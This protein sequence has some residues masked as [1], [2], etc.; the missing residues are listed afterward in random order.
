MFPPE[1]Q[2]PR[3]SVLARVALAAAAIVVGVV[4]GVAAPAFAPP[5]SAAGASVTV[6]NAK[7]TAVADPDYAT[8]ITV[9]GR[10]FQSIQGG[11]G[12]IYVLFGW[13]S[14]GSWKPSAGGVIGA[15]YRYVP[16]TES[17]DNAGFE[18]FIAF[19]GSETESA[20][21]GVIAA[22]GSWSTTMNIPGATFE[23]LDRT[24]KS[25]EVDCLKVTCGVIT[26]GAHGVKNGNNETFT[27]VTFAAP[28]PAAAD[29]PATASAG[30]AGVARVGYTT[31]SAVAGN[32]LS[33]TGKGFTPGEQVVATLD[34]GVAAVGPLTAGA[35][36]DVAG[37]MQLPMDIR[38]GTHLLTLRGAAT[39]TVAESE[40]TIAADSAAATTSTTEAATPV[41]PYLLLGLSCLVAATL[42]LTS[43]VTMLVRRRRARPKP[44]TAEP[45]RELEHVE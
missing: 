18:R 13:V 2:T 40:V 16:D 22:D 11:F 17:K 32:A 3:A 8:P 31:S 25:S 14:S 21:N 20:A 36:G 38:G 42:L 45:A 41:W 10:G 44:V 33:F 23:S 27:P 9:S 4:V 28:T 29:V 5:A 24:G 26:I 34:D 19:P 43:I 6:S 7:G 30:S 1:A 37:V 35:S 12:G 39:D 15:D